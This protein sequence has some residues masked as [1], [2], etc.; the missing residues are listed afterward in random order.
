MKREKVNKNDAKSYKFEPSDVYEVTYIKAKHHEIGDKDLVSLPVAI[1]FIN[2]GKINS[3]PE[4]DSA[5]GKYG[6]GD[7]IKAKS[8]KQ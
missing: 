5:I 2:D 8:K 7:L 4:I 6:M 3:T 1:M